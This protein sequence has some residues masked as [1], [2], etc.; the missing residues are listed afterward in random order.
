MDMRTAAEP[1]TLQQ[2]GFTVARHRSTV[3]Q[4]QEMAETNKVAQF[5]VPPINQAYYDELLPVIRKLSGAR[6]VIPQ[7]TGLTVRYSARST[8]QT[9]AGAASFIHLD[10]TRHSFQGFLEA[11]L[12][13]LK[14]P[15]AAWNRVVLYQTWRV[16]ALPTPVDNVLALCDRRSVPAADVIFYDAIIGDKNTELESV[17]ARSC[18]YGAGHRWWYHSGMGAEDVLV[19]IGYDSA[20]PDAVQPFH[21]GIDVPGCEQATPRASLE[22]RFFAFYD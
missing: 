8:R 5:G 21:T 18:R 3:A 1:L 4:T 2:Q 20:D 10:V 11:S 14:E 9:W 22:A 7:A 17:E 6:D 13:P 12:T 16:V 15:P 19:F